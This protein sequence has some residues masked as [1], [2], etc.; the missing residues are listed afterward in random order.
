LSD[1]LTRDRLIINQK[2]KIIEVNQE[3]KIFDESGMEIGAIRQEGQSILKKIFRIF[4]NYDQ[5]F[6]HTLS[7]Y[8]ANGTKTVELIRPR[9][10]FKSKVLVKDGSGRDVGR[11][12]QQNMI[13]KIRFG[14]E[15]AGGESLGQ[16]KAE[17]WRAWDFSIV[18]QG[19][20][21]IGRI[22]KKWE[23][24]VKNVFTTADN[25]MLE[26]SSPVQGDLRLIMLASA[27]GI[28]TALKQDS[29]GLS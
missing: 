5:F 2:V 8:D 10:I 13:G 1:L 17:N 22:T 18:D 9:K 19:D 15:G 14:L 3:F 29:R 4:G 25:Y 7:V 28:D 11:I 27:A 21:E 20:Q 16:I 12:V 26:I 24:L 23:G 6:T